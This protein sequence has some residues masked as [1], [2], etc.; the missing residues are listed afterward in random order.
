MFGAPTTNRQNQINN[1]RN[2][3]QNDFDD[4]AQQARA[5]F[6]QEELNRFNEGLQRARTNMQ[7]FYDTLTTQVPSNVSLG[8]VGVPT[9]LFGQSPAINFI[10]NVSQPQ[11]EA[12]VEQPQA[13]PMMPT[14]PNTMQTAV[15]TDAPPNS[16]TMAI[17]TDAPPNTTTM[18]INTDAPNTT[19]I[20]LSPM[21]SLNSSSSSSS[22]NTS[23]NGSSSSSSMNAPPPSSQASNTASM[24][25]L[26]YS[27]PPPPPNDDNG[28][29][30]EYEN[31]TP[32]AQ[33]SVVS[34]NSSVNAPPPSINTV[35]NRV[36]QYEN[37]SGSP[38]SSTNNTN[39]AQS[40]GSANISSHPYTPSSVGSTSPNAPSVNGSLSPSNF[41]AP[42]DDFSYFVAPPDDP[43]SV[44]LFGELPATEGVGQNESVATTQ[45]VIPPTQVVGD[46][47]VATTQQVMQP[48]EVVGDGSVT[49]TEV[50]MQPTE[51]IGD[52][53]VATTE[54]V[55][56]DPNVA[57]TSYAPPKRRRRGRP[58][59]AE[60]AAYNLEQ[61]K[62][63]MKE[64]AKREKRF[65]EKNTDLLVKQ[66]QQE[67]EEYDEN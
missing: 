34:S 39:Q 17:N 6:P 64:K 63:S 65:I 36:E 25:S 28:A 50:V 35:R 8:N 58:T 5:E 10:N 22:S 45:Q 4:I 9:N 53:S 27:P 67:D 24:G 66:V 44:N 2:D 33:A 20:G 40:R 14:P 23:M 11:Q 48:T 42:D 61:K 62:K 18:A 52:G 30:I 7:N 21:S 16:T 12:Q 46:E 29:I 1:L 13:D 59:K 57:S 19:S 3:T 49:T 60:V 15:N 55:G 43:P 41:V 38:P 31:L 47:S 32:S 51:V 56:D 54:V 26:T 37:L